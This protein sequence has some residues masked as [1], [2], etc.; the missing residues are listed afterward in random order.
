MRMSD[1]MEFRKLMQSEAMQ[2]FKSNATEAESCFL[3]FV[4]VLEVSGARFFSKLFLAL[5]E[6]FCSLLNAFEPH[7]SD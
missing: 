7:E 6:Q 4:K 5:I 1:L 3:S 2:C